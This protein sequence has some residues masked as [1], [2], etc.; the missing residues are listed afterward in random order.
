MPTW[1]PKHPTLQPAPETLIRAAGTKRLVEG[2]YTTFED[3]T[4]C[5]RCAKTVSA[6]QRAACSNS[7]CPK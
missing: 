3:K 5:K 6:N 1:T 2:D 4:Y 7:N